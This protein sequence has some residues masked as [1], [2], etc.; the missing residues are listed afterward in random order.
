M[1]IFA[2]VLTRARRAFSTPLSSLMTSVREIKTIEYLRQIY[3]IVAYQ[4]RL[5]SLRR[6]FH[7]AD[8]FFNVPYY[9]P[10]LVVVYSVRVGGY[11]RLFYFLFY[12]AASGIS[13]L[14]I[15]RGLPVEIEYAVETESY[16]LN[17]CVAQ[18]GKHDRSHADLLGGFPFVFKVGRFFGDYIESLFHCLVQYVFK[19]H[20]IALARGSCCLLRETPCR[21]PRA[22]CPSPQSK[23]A[24]S[25]TLKICR[26]WRFC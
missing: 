1:R 22:P 26:K 24:S 7:R 11:A 18:R 25:K 9:F 8:E 16:V 20:G 10:R 13:I 23:P 5:V 17:S 12:G 19:P 15:G 6:G 21:K 14:Q 4:T 2:T 3:K